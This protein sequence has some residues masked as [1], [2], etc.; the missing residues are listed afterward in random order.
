MRGR[1]LELR[2]RLPIPASLEHGDRHAMTGRKAAALG[3]PFLGGRQR[4]E[5]FTARQLHA[6]RIES[7]VIGRALKRAEALRD[8]GRGEGRGRQQQGQHQTRQQHP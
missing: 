4:L 2:G 8:G 5:R 6:F 1:R 7:Q 3:M